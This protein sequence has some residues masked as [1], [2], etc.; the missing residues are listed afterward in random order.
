MEYFEIFQNIAGPTETLLLNL[1]NTENRE[2]FSNKLLNFER[3]ET[4]FNIENFLLLEI[5]TMLLEYFLILKD[6]IEEGEII[7]RNIL[8]YPRQF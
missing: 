7:I 2:I 6:I 4:P 3:Y 8:K 5:E 1:F